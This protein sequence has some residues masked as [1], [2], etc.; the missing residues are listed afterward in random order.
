MTRLFGN[1]AVFVLGLLAA[2]AS[3]GDALDSVESGAD[4][5]QFEGPFVYDDMDQGVYLIDTLWILSEQAVEEIADQGQTPEE[6][7]DW[8]LDALNATLE[9]SLI[10]S[11]SVRSVGYHVLN[12]ADVE[13]VGVS[14]SNTN[15]NISNALNWL[16][17]YRNAYGADKVVIVAGT[18]EGSSGAALGGGDV[19]A[20]W[21]SFLPLEHE[22]GHQMGGAHCN[23]GDPATYN[24]GYP[25][26]GYDQD[27]Y[28]I[29]EGQ[30]DAPDEGGTRMC[31]NSV[32]LFSNPE[33]WLTVDEIQAMADEGLAPKGNWALLANEEGLI[34]FGDSL[35]ANMAKQWRDVEEYAA[36]RVPTVRYAGDAAASYVKDDCVG[37]FAEE[38]YGGLVSEVCAG[39]TAVDLDGVSSVQVGSNVHTNLYSDAAFGREA[40]CGGMIQR[41]A[42][43]SPSLDAL[44]EHHQTSS[45]DGAVKS[46]AVYAPGDRD[47]HYRNEGP[48]SFYGSGTNPLCDGQAG[49]ELVLMPDNRDWAATAA[50]YGEEV[51]L[52][53]VVEFELKT[54]HS[55]SDPLADGFTFFFGHS[56]ESYEETAPD[57]AQLGFLANGTGHAVMFNTWTSQVGLRDGDW[58]RIGPDKVHS[59]DTQNQWIPIRIEVREDGVLVQ[60]DGQDLIQESVDLNSAYSGVGFTAGTGYYTAEYRLREIRYSE[61]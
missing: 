18:E 33:V 28:P 11:S 54:M 46:V 26:S 51:E 34:Q 4:A 8:R 45:L 12:D 22:F 14:I 42:F 40:M 21:V 31:G 24:Y 23:D 10:D 17:S 7:L 52:P 39:E 3:D 49:D 9:R 61:L 57:R 16:G 55:N 13:R 36:N 48:Y 37:F 2:C 56:T 38:G 53:F 35:Y 15:V 30:G 25:I 50:I 19:S 29:G 58:S 60:W 27:G 44:A 47:A 43:S 20:H 5:P 59:S 32:A 6:F 41:L 1:P